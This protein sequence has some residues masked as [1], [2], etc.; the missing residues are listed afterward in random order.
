[1]EFEIS[2]EKLQSIRQ[3]AVNNEF[4]A[5]SHELACDSSMGEMTAEEEVRLARALVR[6]EA[7]AIL[8][9]FFRQREE[10]YKRRGTE[11]DTQ[12]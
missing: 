5:R 7:N 1:M 2:E 12:E 6:R 8:R 10:F 11:P 3:E 4:L 9:D